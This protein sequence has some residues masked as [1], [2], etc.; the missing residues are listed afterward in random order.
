MAVAA[1]NKPGRTNNLKI[2]IRKH[3][4]YTKDFVHLIY[5]QIRRS[6]EADR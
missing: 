6:N 2:K 4:E 1:A 3:L 5:E